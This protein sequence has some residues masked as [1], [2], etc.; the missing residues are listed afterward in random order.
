MSGLALLLH[1]RGFKITGSDATES[2]ITSNLRK[3]GIEV[4]IPQSKKNIV[5]GIDLVVYTAAISS[6]NEEF[7]S[8]KDKNIPMLVRSQFLGEVME[9]YKNVITVSGT[10][11]KTTTTSMIS[12]ITLA[13][14]LD[15]TITVGGMLS[16]IGGNI[17]I[18]GMDYFVAEACEYQNSFHDFHPTSAV[19]LN[20]EE[21]HLDFFKDEE[22]IRNSFKKFAMLLS[23]DQ[24]LII[25]KNITKFDEFIENLNCNIITYNGVNRELK[26]DETNKA[27]ADYS[28]SNIVYDE[29]YRPSFD[30][31]YHGDKIIE[32][33]KLKVRGSASISSALAAI[34]V[35]RNYNIDVNIIKNALNGFDG[36]G[37]RFESKGNINGALVIDDYAHNPAEVNSVISIAKNIVKNKLWLV[38]QPHTYSRTKTFLNEFA[39]K[40][41]NV[42]NLILTDIYAARE[43]NTYNISSKDI[44]DVINNKYKNKNCKAV[45]IEDSNNFEKIKAYLREHVKDGDLVLIVGAGNIEKLANNILN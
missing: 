22:D 27:K 44:I 42:D 9:N 3:A 45:Y 13:A 40:L 8:A 1:D 38:Y 35:T 19:I 29:E 32:N 12:E 6:D 10:H 37:R 18:G 25:N 15:P 23:K 41:S 34:A 5:D 21:D 43:K 14:N 7:I 20:I 28:A 4:N 24:Y 36:V 2:V 16:S 26:I 17:R 31:Y 11:G 33:L 30:V 39:D